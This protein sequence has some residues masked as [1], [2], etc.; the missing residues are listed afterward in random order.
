[1]KNK[2]C[3]II[4]DLLPSYVDNICSEASKEWV[5]AHLAEC[6]ECRAT[7]QNFKSTEISAKQLDFAQLDATKKVKKNVKI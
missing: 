1:M 7:A 4:K 6:E 5:E 3:D 2:E